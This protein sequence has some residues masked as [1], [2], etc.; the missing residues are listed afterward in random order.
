[1]GLLQRTIE[2]MPLVR[3][4]VALARVRHAQ[5]DHAGALASLAQAGAWFADLQIADPLALTRLHI[6]QARLWIQQGDLDTARRWASESSLPADTALAC[7]H[8]L[9]LVRLHLV[10]YRYT[11][12]S[13]LLSQASTALA[14]VRDRAEA[15]DWPV[16]LL[17][18]RVLRALTLYMQN[19]LPNAFAALIDALALAESGGYVRIFLDEGE[20]MRL[21]MLDFRFWIVKQTPTEKQAIIFAYV[22]KL[23]ATFP[24]ADMAVGPP[25]PS[26]ALSPPHPVSS[27]LV[28]PLSS[29][30]LEVLQLIAAGLS[31]G[32]VAT[33]LVVTVGTVKSHVNH[34][35]SKLDVTS[36][37][38]AIMRARSLGLLI[39]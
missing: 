33:R 30:E 7:E 11:P 9:T 26:V 32:E 35:F 36:R 18:E 22:E 38:Q 15:D 14:A 4:H 2:K 37:T 10:Q 39:G 31:N 21:L 28:D 5:G 13:A 12:E 3:G 16:Y 19:N 17:E 20:P 23:F 25:R 34:I 6:Q 8:W 24:H 29:R 1:L 27:S